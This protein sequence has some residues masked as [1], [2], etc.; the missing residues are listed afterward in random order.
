MH[1]CIETGISKMTKTN[2]VIKLTTI[3][4]CPEEYKK[5]W[6]GGIFCE[7]PTQGILDALTLAKLLKFKYISM[8]EKQLSGDFCLVI[9]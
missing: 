2:V 8:I 9:K 1:F 5:F 4:N 3:D 6:Q 7:H